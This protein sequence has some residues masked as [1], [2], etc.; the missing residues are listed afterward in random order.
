MEE[1]NQHYLLKNLGRS[2]VL[3]ALTGTRAR[4]SIGRDELHRALL[5]NCLENMAALGF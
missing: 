3:V 2:C 1:E 5:C 4:A